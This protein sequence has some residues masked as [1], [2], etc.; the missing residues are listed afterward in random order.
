MAEIKR[1][2]ALGNFDGL[3]PGHRAV[4]E[5]AVRQREN[6]LIPTVLLLDP[7][8]CNVEGFQPHKSLL[9]DGDKLRLLSD[10]GVEVVKTDFLKIKDYEPVRFFEELLVGKLN[11]AAVCC[12]FNYRFGKNGSGN[13][14]LLQKL[15][16][17]AGIGFESCGVVNFEGEPVS[18]T[19]I[20]TA[21]EEG[22]IETANAMLGRPFGYK[23]EVVHGDKI[24]RLLDCPTLN[25]LFPQEL[26][27]PAYG[28]YSSETL[29]DGKW[30]RS[31]TNIGRR[32]SFDNDEQRSETHVI[33]F[34]G[35]L[36]GKHIEVRL[37]AYKRKEMK[38]GSM[39]ELRAQLKIDRE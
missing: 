16:V 39:D 22:R 26:I 17:G 12:G 19:R 10:M 7:L 8:P 29:I 20:R 23:L 18:S 38:F 1:A 36:Y 3:H 35:D 31:V 6:G 32:P 14:E 33:G 34:N 28:V 11:A 25:Q 2:V 15:C 24:G 5:K 27:V 4:I 9:T 37:L 13:T 21:I 30:L